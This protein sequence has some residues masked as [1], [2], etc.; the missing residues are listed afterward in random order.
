MPVI[1]LSNISK[2]YAGEYILNDVSFSVDE[3]DKIGLIGL[4]GTGKTTLIK[5]ILGAIEH[6]ISLKTKEKGR[7]SSKSNLSI[8]YLS[9]NF[10]LNSDNTVYD[11]MLSIFSDVIEDHQIIKKLNVDISFA[12]GEELAEKMRELAEV[13]SRYEQAEGYSIDYKIKQVLNGLGIDE[14]QYTLLISNLSGGQKS[15]IALGKL[16]LQE[17]EL[18][19]LDEPTNHLDIQAIEWLENF[20]K[21][22]SKSFILISH[23]RYFLDNVINRVIEIENKSTRAYAGNY[24]EFLVQKE[25]IKRGELKAF[26]KEQEKVEKMKAFIQKYKAG[27][28]SKQARGRQKL[29]D[30]MDLSENPEENRKNMKL[31]FETEKMP[32]ENVLKVKSISKAYGNNLLFDKVNINLYRGERIGIVGKNGIGKSTLLR[33]I[34]HKEERDKGEIIFGTNVKMGYYDQEHGDLDFSHTILEELR[35]KYPLSEEEARTIAGGFLFSDEDIFKD[36]SSLSGGERAR[37]SFIK[38]ILEKPN[39]LILDEP[40]NHLDIYSREILEEALD[41]YDGTILLISHDRYFLDRIVDK[42]Y[43]ISDHGLCYHKDISTYKIN[44]EKKDLKKDDKEES[45]LSYEE[46]KKIKNRLRSLEK[47]YETLEKK[48][49]KDEN[50][51]KEIEELYNKAGLLNDYDKLMKYQNDIEKIDDMILADLEEMESIEEELADL[52]KKI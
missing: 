42:I 36:I 16:L 45:A 41:D 7:I 12:K 43:E 14:S 37:I 8:G 18:L 31:K 21:N 3:K 44:E 30:R 27:V 25:L 24:T 33:L 1:Q 40:T 4:N 5:I 22:Y 50:E 15:R 10:D 51:K 32:G 39:L 29:L 13:S 52:Q 26:E 48:I 28:K 35:S 34:A 47:R 11:E 2:A 46:Q 23:D 17:P 19:I 38:L 49:E 9:Q 6:D 20:L